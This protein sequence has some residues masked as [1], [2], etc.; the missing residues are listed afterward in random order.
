MSQS[1][2]NALGRTSELEISPEDGFEVV[3]IES[4]VLGPLD[5]VNAASDRP[6]LDT[7][8]MAEFGFSL[9]IFSLFLACL[10]SVDWMFVIIIVARCD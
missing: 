3:A 5:G 9:F 8:E 1:K 7:A 2:L 6:A 4:L 10:L